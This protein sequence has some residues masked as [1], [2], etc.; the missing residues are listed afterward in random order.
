MGR[1][2]CHRDLCRIPAG[3][4][5]HGTLNGYANLGCGCEGCTA[6]NRSWWR[7]SRAHAASSRTCPNC[8]GP[9]GLYADGTCNTCREYRR[10]N[11]VVRPPELYDPPDRHCVNCVKRMAGPLRQGRCGA[12]A[13]Y[14]D[15]NGVERPERLW[16]AGEV[17][18]ADDD[19]LVVGV[20]ADG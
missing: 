15:R 20:T 16:R 6:A 4:G 11:G 8:A 13:R 3:D 9:G 17:D 7:R 12:C 19:H 2:G 1:C 10:R 14:W 5:R 18:A